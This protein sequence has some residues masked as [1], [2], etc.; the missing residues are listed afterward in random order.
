MASRASSETSATV[1]GD[2]IPAL[3]GLGTTWYRRGPRYWLRR[4]WTAFGLLLASALL[5]FFAVSVYR[6]FTSEWSATAR[7]VSD[8]VQVAGACVGVVWGWL[9]QRRDHRRRLLDPPS[10]AESLA[11]RR[12][13][14]SRAP[15]RVALGRGL[16]LV[17][18]PVLPMVAAWCVGWFAGHV[19]VR[20]Y[21]SEVGARRWLEAHPTGS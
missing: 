20:E 13:Q 8:W 14:R 5:V 16:A 11:A 7:T 1:G 2:R 12:G 6:G 18:A 15:G 17:L 9:R 21:P 3:P 10:P 4:C 19:T